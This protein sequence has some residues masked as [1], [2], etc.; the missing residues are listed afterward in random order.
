MAPRRHD[1]Q[2]ILE[3]ICPHVYFQP[4]ANVQMSYPAIVYERGRANTKFADNKPYDITK[5]YSLTL[6]SRNPDESIFEALAALPMCAHER[7]F[8][9]DNL[10][11]D[12]FNIY[13]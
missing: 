4:P 6:I 12:V 8:V 7:F 9:V 10:N 2:E 3:G 13:F 5:Q 1:L 11:H